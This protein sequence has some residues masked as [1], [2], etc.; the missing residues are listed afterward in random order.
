MNPNLFIP[1]NYFQEYFVDKQTGLPLAGGVVYFWQ[2]IN[3]N[4]PKAVYEISGSPPNYTYTALP[5]PITLTNAGTFADSTGNDVAV[6]GYPYDAA[7][8]PDNYY[9]SVFAAPSVPPYPPVGTPIITRENVPGVTVSEGPGEAG[10]LDYRNVLVNSQFVE[11][12]FNPDV[13]MTI[14]YASGTTTQQIAPGW[15]I[16][17]DATGSGTVTV[18]RNS[19]TGA[20][21]AAT[22]PPYSLT[23]NPSG[24]AGITSIIL[25]QRLE[26]N[27]NIF[28]AGYLNVG[29]ALNAGTSPIT[30]Y[31]APQGTPVVPALATFSNTSG[32]W[33]YENATSEL[34]ANGTNANNADSGYVDIQFSLTPGAS[35]TLSSMQLVFLGEN[36]ATLEP[37]ENLPYN[38]EPVI[39]QKSGN[40]F[41][42][43]PLYAYKPIPSLLIGWDFAVNPTQFGEAG[44]PFATGVNSA[45]YTWDQTIVYQ[46]LDSSFTFNKNANH[47]LV[48]TSAK[49]SQVA[50]VQY[51]DRANC[52][53]IFNDKSSVHLSIS[54]NSAAPISGNV[55]LWACTNASV[56]T[57]PAT[58]FGGISATGV[59]QTITA[60]WT[61]IPNIY[62]KSSFDVPV[63]SATNSESNDINLNG[64]DL[65]GAVPSSTATYFAIVVGFSSWDAADTLTLNSI[66][67][68]S[69]DIATRPAP[70]SIDE[71]LRDCERYYEMSYSSQHGDV[72]GTVTARNQ[73]TAPMLS[74]YVLAGPQARFIE[75]TFGFQFRTQKRV[76]SVQGYSTVTIYSPFDGAAGAV[77]ANYDGQSDNAAN[78]LIT[79]WNAPIINDK[80]VYFESNSIGTTFAPVNLRNGDTPLICWINYHFVADARL[81]VVD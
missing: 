12:L 31:Y 27:P 23:I 56:P 44:G 18:T 11:V 7:G 65:A 62:Q 77:Y 46:T 60:G 39:T 78:D 45:S 59:P 34:L 51:L 24:G 79:V 50:V 20:L 55:T 74:G 66:A 22:N 32:V 6:Y 25:Y 41:Y 1:F 14:T 29:M 13:G 33:V 75:N 72:A 4:N 81:G 35:T 2:D 68:C 64:W 16:K 52:E 48:L 30:A 36:T 17:I 53:A 26:N 63:A 67:L 8:N 9:V 69:G 15:A 19:L 43:D 42:Y 40:S 10:P 61:Q 5:N 3:R 54:R 80:Y 37:I 49:T 71:A 58:F 21:N 76:P 70:K 38:Q 47:S 57:L 28:S 73:L